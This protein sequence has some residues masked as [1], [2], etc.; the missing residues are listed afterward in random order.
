MFVGICTVELHI[1]DSG[2]LKDKRQVV[3]SIKD[4]IRQN[5]NVSIAEVDGHDLWQRVLLGIACVGNE[6]RY[7][8]GV[9]DKIIELLRGNRS[10]EL[11]KY[12]ME[13]L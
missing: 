12:D 11:L 2:S 9:L 3:K 13:F 6:K 4:R 8:N 10:V 5:Y 1:P 7:I